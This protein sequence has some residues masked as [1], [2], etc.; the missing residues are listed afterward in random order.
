MACTR[1]Q[2]LSRCGRTLAE[3]EVGGKSQD[4]K[5]DLG[6]RWERTVDRM[7]VLWAVNDTKGASVADQADA[8]R[9][10][11]LAVLISVT[12]T[13]DKF[14]ISRLASPPC[15]APRRMRL[16]SVSVL[17]PYPGVPPGF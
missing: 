13:R 9:L 17:S 14:F 3:S 4:G 16:M 7:V 15:K 2:T 12:G 6:V 10:F 11:V 5:K 1:S 8:T